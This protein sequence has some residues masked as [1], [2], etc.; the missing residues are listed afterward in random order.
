M[1]W[2]QDLPTRCPQG[3]GPIC[4]H[5]QA[6]RPG[7]HHSD[8]P[9][10]FSFGQSLKKSHP[11]VPGWLS[12]LSVRLRSAQV[13][14]SWFVGSRPT[15]GSVLTPQPGACFPF[16]VSLS[17]SAPLPLTLSLSVK[18]KQT[19][20]RAIGCYKTPGRQTPPKYPCPLSFYYTYSLIL[21][22]NGTSVVTSAAAARPMETWTK[23]SISCRRKGMENLGSSSDADGHRQGAW[24]SYPTSLSV[25]LLLRRRCAHH[26]SRG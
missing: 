17:L 7:I 26:R 1:K 14:V 15:S 18:N 25:G 13:R 4:H 10:P 19:L 22:L 23:S 2:A 16:C 3:S 6:P 24:T 11:G 8:R 12:R 9:L 21:T 20:K 5:P